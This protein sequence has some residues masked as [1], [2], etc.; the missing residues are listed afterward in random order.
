MVDVRVPELAVDRPLPVLALELEHLARQ[1][2]EVGQ[3]R[4]RPEV[5]RQGERR[6]ARLLAPDDELEH[7][8]GRIVGFRVL[9]TSS[10][11]PRS[12]IFSVLLMMISVPSGKRAE[13]DDDVRALG[14]P[15]IDV[16]QV[17]LRHRQEVAAV[18]DLG[19][20]DVLPP[21]RRTKR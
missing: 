17:L 5:G 10:P 1:G 7:L 9:P 8:V 14:H 20:L 3:G 16:L 2:A 6:V 15:E 21:L 11:R 4:Q 13:V 19:E 12:R 18:G